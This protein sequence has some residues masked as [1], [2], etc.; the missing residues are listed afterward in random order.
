MDWGSL[1][2]MFGLIFV[3]ELGDKTQLA[4]VTQTCKYRKP[5]V[6]FLGASAA[7]I[8]VTALGAIGGQILGQFVPE[9]VLRVVAAVA[10]VVMGIFTARE[11]IRAGKGTSDE[12]TCDCPEDEEDAESVSAWDWKA[13]SSTFALLFAAELGDKT[14]LAVLS[15]AGKRGDVWPVFI[16][17]ALALTSV[18]ALGVVGGQALCRLIPT[19][20]LLLVSAI[21]FVVMGILMGVRVM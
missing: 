9:G 13:F 19:R 18:T 3:A 1:L 8:T 6:I 7:L 17:G 21:A 12:A 20:S 2:S 14:Q 11:A 16:G 5:W 15:M 10:F 4:V